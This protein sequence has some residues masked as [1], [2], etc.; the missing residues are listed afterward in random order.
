VPLESDKGKVKPLT[1]NE[2]KQI[3]D[4]LEKEIEGAEVS[5][6]IM[7]YQYGHLRGAIKILVAAIEAGTFPAAESEVK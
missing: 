3:A 1:D 4:R 7:A 2:R 6:E 5:S